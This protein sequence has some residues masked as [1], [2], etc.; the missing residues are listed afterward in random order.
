[1]SG[2][3]HR[4]ATGSHSRRR[5]LLV[6]GI[7]QPETVPA[8]LP[9]RTSEP[10]F[11]PSD[12]SEAKLTILH[13]LKGTHPLTWVFTGDGGTQGIQS[14]T[15]ARNFS[16]HFSERLRWELRRFHD[17]VINTGIFGDRI[18]SLLK[19][20]EFRAL[21]FKPDVVLLQGGLN[22]CAAGAGSLPDFERTLRRVI[23]RIQES[24]SI[25]VLQT[26]HKPA[27]VVLAERPALPE[28][29]AAIRRIADLDDIP[30]VDHWR[31]WEFRNR[32]EREL[33]AW[34]DDSGA[35]PNVYGHREM[36]RLICH[37]FGIFSRESATCALEVP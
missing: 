1:M 25:P 20:L 3:Q 5:R 7:A 13:L 24:G 23:G 30:L 18:S 4:P 11:L 21:R 2:S 8:E 15:G 36:F 12:G 6:Q 33:A 32:N 37:E 26:P 9:P 27:A 16:E 29:V 10:R 19:M 22:D 28:Y 14:T 34:L 17:V 35:Q 31:H